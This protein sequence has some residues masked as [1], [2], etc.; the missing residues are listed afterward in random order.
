MITILYGEQSPE[1]YCIDMRKANALKDVNLEGLNYDS[2]K[3]KFDGETANL[4]KTYPLIESKRGIVLEVESLKDLD[5]EDFYAYIKKPASFTELVII[6]RNADKRLKLYKKLCTEGMEGV[7]AVLCD[8]KE[9]TQEKLIQTI[10]YELKKGG[11][12]I[13]KDALAEFLSR[14]NY[15][16][17]RD[18]NLL[19]ATGYLK[20]L[21][22]V[23]KG[24]DKPMVQK[25]VPAFKEAD[26][27]KLVGALIRG[28]AGN[29]QEQVNMASPKDAI[30]ILCLILRSFRIAWKRKYF[31][32]VSAT[33]NEALQ[34]L[35]TEV[36]KK[37]IGIINKTVS[38]IKTGYMPEDMALKVACGEL[39][40]SIN[41]K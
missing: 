33:C 36:L 17:N 25:Y 34:E 5:N 12:S 13:K 18:M 29:L 26:A 22:A 32:D 16:E 7:T 31:N 14:I 41:Q 21:M 23:N 15:D 11:A 24:I 39:A 4:A 37:C 38:G 30:G 40:A 6:C 1:P 19:T 10:G 28:D 27:F 8:K 35:D 20:T 9:V 2:I 3:G